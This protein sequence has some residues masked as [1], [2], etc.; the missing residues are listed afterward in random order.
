MLLL[1]VLGSGGVYFPR[2]RFLLPGFPLLM[3]VARALARARRT[4]VVRVVLGAATLW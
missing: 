1:V 4:A 2:A 3:P